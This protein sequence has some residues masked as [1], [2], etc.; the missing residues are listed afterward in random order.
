MPMTRPA[1]SF[2]REGMEMIREAVRLVAF[3]ASEERLGQ[4][5]AT[6][7]TPNP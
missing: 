3:E 4:D 7:S 5:W 2:T 6:G 1:I